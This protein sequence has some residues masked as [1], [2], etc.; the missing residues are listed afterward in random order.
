MFD[1]GT[2]ILV[3]TAAN[4]QLP[5]GNECALSSAGL[6]CP[7]GLPPK[8]QLV[9]GRSRITITF[10]PGD[11]SSSARLC[12]AAACKQCLA[13]LPA[14][15]E[16]PRWL[17][18][19]RAPRFPVEMVSDA[20]PSVWSLCLK[21]ACILLSLEVVRLTIGRN[22][23]ARGTST[24][25]VD[26]ASAKNG[27]GSTGI[28]ATGIGAAPVAVVALKGAELEVLAVLR[29]RLGVSAPPKTAL[30]DFTLTRFL[31][32]CKSDAGAAATMYLKYLSWR[33]AENVDAVLT[34]PPL[35]AEAEQM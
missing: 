6:R 26:S 32:A 8:S 16:V 1:W 12:K 30:G 22:R 15:G 33:E 10:H 23:S 4:A 13:A 3:V 5:T 19:H 29:Q 34:E 11:D 2:V 9:L 35:S 20:P 21:A 25:G 18:C 24:Q 7:L 14:E 17:A 28:G 31:R 27:A